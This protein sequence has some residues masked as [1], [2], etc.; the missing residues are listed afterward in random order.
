MTNMTA[1]PSAST[2]GDVPIGLYPVTIA[3]ARYNGLYEG[4]KWLAFGNGL[5]DTD[6]SIEM[7]FGDDTVCVEWWFHH[8]DDPLIGRGAT[9]NA[10]LS[11]LLAK[12]V[13]VVG[14][15]GDG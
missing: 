12:H 9:P 10:A 13:D 15:G 5:Y 2:V 6:A 11:D 3:Q 14:D 4:G 1:E 8:R 7:A